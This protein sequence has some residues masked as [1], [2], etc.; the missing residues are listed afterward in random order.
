L[1]VKSF[2]ADFTFIK[3]SMIIVGESLFIILFF[4][5]KKP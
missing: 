3:L 2:K 5:A 4:I 1:I